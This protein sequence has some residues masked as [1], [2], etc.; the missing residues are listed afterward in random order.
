[1]RARTGY[2]SA[3]PMD[4]LSGN[5]VEKTL[6]TKIAA[7]QAGPLA[8]AGP[9]GASMR[10]PFF[11]ASP[12]VARVNLAMELPATGLKFEKRKDAQHAEVNFLGIAYT[13]QGTVAARFSDTLKLDFASKEEAEQAK[14]QPLHYENQFD[15]ASGKYNFKIVFSEG[16]D[17]FGKLEMP[18]E[19]DSF[20]SDQF[21][22]SGLALS[23]EYHRTSE[24]GAALDAALIEDKKPLIAGGLQIVPTGNPTFTKSD[25]AI[26]YVELYDP[27]LASTDPQNTPVVGLQMRV[28]D[29]KTGDQKVDT[30]LFKLDPAPPLGNPTVSLG[31]KMPVS[32]LAPGAYQ[33]EVT[34][35]DSTGQSAKRTVDFD[36]Q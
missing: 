28:L 14:K 5:P 35:A 17:N 36:I 11:F 25:L 33:L 34:A 19:I 12:N 31:E 23:K 1:V 21:A 7:A 6:E 10:M 15:I 2:C 30:G 26:F 9:Q 24:M 29:R 16:G 22:V 13:A 8:A 27:L 20:K 32:G 3:K 4:L 18:L